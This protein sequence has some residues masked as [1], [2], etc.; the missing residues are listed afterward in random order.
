[1]SRFVV[2]I[3]MS[4]DGYIAD[5]EGGVGWLESFETDDYGYEEFLDSI[6]SIIVGRVTY[7]QIAGFGQW[8]YGKIPTL[9]WSGTNIEDLPGGTISWSED[10]QNTAKWLTGQADGKDVWI[11]GG[12]LSIKAFLD[13][14]MRATEVMRRVTFTLGER[15]EL[16][17]AEVVP[18]L[19]WV[20][21][22]ILIAMLIGGA[23]SV[24][25]RLGCALRGGAPILAGFFAGTVLVPILLPWIP[26][27]AFSLKGAIVGAAVVGRRR[28][29]AGVDDHQA[30]PGLQA[31]KAALRR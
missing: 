16:V 4:L 22:L 1:M 19:K 23:D 6:G 5:D 27:R 17:G 18:A 13:A 28:R 10:V 3:A 15:L 25:E 8:P 31:L 7:E 9:V 21:L 29:R 26:G 20:V 14:R 2:Y 24:L 30:A 11:L 12:A